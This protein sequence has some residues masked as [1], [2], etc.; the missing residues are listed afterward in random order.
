MKDKQ[1]EEV[2]GSIE[3]RIRH[4]YNCGYQQ[5]YE[6]GKN[7]YGTEIRTK[8]DVDEAYQ[9]GLED[10]WEC[11][12]KLVLNSEDGGL[13]VKD[14]REIFNFNNFF[15]GSYDVIKDYSAQEAMQKIK[16]YEERQTR[17]DIEKVYDTIEGAERYT[18]VPKQTEEKIVKPRWVMIPK[19][20]TC[21]YLNSPIVPCNRCKDNSEYVPKN[22][23][24]VRKESHDL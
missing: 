22:A 9:H 6:D 20:T 15:E 2:M 3:N 10:A 11:A 4:I 12:R 21:K 19:C 5:G 14:I 8:Q 13:R 16:D 7:S 23:E 17:Y 1:I 18:F 24:D